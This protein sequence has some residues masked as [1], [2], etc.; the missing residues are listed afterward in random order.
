MTHRR[1]APGTMA[2]DGRIALPRKRTS[3]RSLTSG[4]AER[5]RGWMVVEGTRSGTLCRLVGLRW[6]A[7]SKVN[8]HLINPPINFL[9]ISIYLSPKFS[10]STQCWRR[11]PLSRR[12]CALVIVVVALWTD[13]QDSPHGRVIWVGGSITSSV[14]MWTSNKRLMGLILLLIEY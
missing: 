2:F 3:K 13:T 9:S 14:L 5:K 10:M 11:R 8:F 1:I 6:A 7:P 12:L 4:K